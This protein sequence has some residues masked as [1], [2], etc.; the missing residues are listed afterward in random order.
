MKYTHDNTHEYE[1]YINGY[2]QAAKAPAPNINDRVNEVNT[3]SHEMAETIVAGMRPEHFNMTEYRNTRKY[4]TYAIL[5]TDIYMAVK[6][7]MQADLYQNNEEFDSYE[8][9][10]DFLQKAIANLR[11]F[12]ANPDDPTLVD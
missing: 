5:K 1:E 10:M 3:K 9:W 2:K 7:I 4:P 8:F 11:K 6:G 12:Y